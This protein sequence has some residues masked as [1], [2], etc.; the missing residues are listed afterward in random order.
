VRRI[1]KP[2]ILKAM[3]GKK[4]APKLWS[5]MLHKILLELG[6][7]RCPVAPC[8]YRYSRAEV[9]ALLCIHVDDGLLLVTHQE[10]FDMFIAAI[11]AHLSKVQLTLPLQKYVGIELDYDRE[12]HRVRCTQ[13][14]FAKE[15]ET[16]G[17]SVETIPMCPSS[18]LRTEPPN[19]DN[20]SLLHIT[21]KLRYLCDRTRH[22]LL[23]ATGEISKG[24]ADAP[25]DAHVRTA[26]KTLRYAKCTAR[27]A[28]I[29]GSLLLPILFAF[30]DAAYHADASSKSRRLGGCLF[31][32][33][34]ARAF[35][36]YCKS[37]TL[38]TQSSTH[39]ELLSLYETTNFV[40]HCRQILEFL[41]FTQTTPTK[42]YCDS[43]SSIDLCSLLKITH[44]T[45]SFNMR[46]NF[47]R[48]CLNTHSTFYT[49]SSQY[50]R[51]TLIL[52]NCRRASWP[53]TWRAISSTLV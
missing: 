6:F 24:G 41:G 42:I 19:P 53:R 18:N 4:Q 13:E 23:C 25:S 14:I 26:Q 34:D 38:V 16:E 30:C 52:L 1:R 7:E 51:F 48:H 12:G 27:R 36:S 8:L 49:H 29:L 39:A 44:K 22:D 43:K 20:E 45:C 21:G 35:Y 33:P 9:H 17:D 31:L 40:L 5:D 10:L 50:C 28:L 11:Q 37:S 32:A 3:Y 46:I 2:P 15:L 47:I